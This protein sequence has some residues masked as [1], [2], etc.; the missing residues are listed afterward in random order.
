MKKYSDCHLNYLQSFRKSICS[1]AKHI[2]ILQRKFFKWSFRSYLYWQVQFL[3]W[4]CSSE[5]D[6][7][8][9]PGRIRIRIFRNTS[10]IFSIP[11]TA[12]ATSATAEIATFIL[13]Y[14]NTF[15][16][17]MIQRERFDVC[18]FFTVIHLLFITK[19]WM[20]S[21]SANQEGYF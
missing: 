21:A 17:D 10:G 3:N 20:C 4:K 13:Q 6:I 2:E 7:K 8:S 19:W 1:R 15:F 12:T 5:E 18:Y 9:N 11:F 16:R 14:I